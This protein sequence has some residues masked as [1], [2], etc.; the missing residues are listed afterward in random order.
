MPVPPLGTPSTPEISAE[1]EAIVTAL[2]DKTPF[3]FVWTT[4]AVKL[5]R[6]ILPV[7]AEPSVSD[8]PLVVA[9]VPLPVR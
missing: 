4:P 7:V 2:E 5:F 6:M 8:W 3:A 9:S 1:P